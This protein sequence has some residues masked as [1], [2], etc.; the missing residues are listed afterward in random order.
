MPSAVLGTSVGKRLP[1]RQVQPASGHQKLSQKVQLSIGTFAKWRSQ[2]QSRPPRGHRT[3]PRLRTV[4]L[5]A[6]VRQAHLLQQGGARAVPDFRTR[7]GQP[8]ARKLPRPER[9][10]RPYGDAFGRRTHHQHF[11]IAFGFPSN[12]L[13]HSSS[14]QGMG[15]PSRVK[16]SAPHLSAT[17]TSG[18]SSP[19]SIT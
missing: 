1:C 5:L 4:T 7:P 2:E 16:K 11:S 14:S 8:L 6:E 10:G 3:E 18:R 12:S 19:R 15:T 13:F 17:A 9:D